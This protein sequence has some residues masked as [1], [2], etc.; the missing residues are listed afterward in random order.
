VITY[1]YLCK[2]CGAH[3]NLRLPPDHETPVCHFC[4]MRLVQVL[5]PPEIAFRGEGWTKRGDH[6]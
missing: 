6:E 3:Y 5:N 1:E 2:H 4:D